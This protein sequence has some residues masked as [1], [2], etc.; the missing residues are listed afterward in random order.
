MSPLA[1]DLGRALE[2]AWREAEPSLPQRRCFFE[3]QAK[4]RV[5]V[6]VVYRFPSEPASDLGNRLTV[7]LQK[8]G[9]EASPMT[10]AMPGVVMVMLELRAPGRFEGGLLRM[11]RMAWAWATPPDEAGEG[12]GPE[13]APTGT[14]GPRD[15]TRVPATVQPTGLA[16]EVDKSLG[17]ALEKVLGVR[18]QLREFTVM[19][20]GPASSAVQLFYAPEGKPS[21]QGQEEQVQQALAQLGLQTLVRGSPE[22]LDVL[23]TGGKL[24]GQTATGG[25]IQVTS[26][27]VEVNVLFQR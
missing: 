5:G 25:T 16:Q 21:W 6:L 26:Q 17:P 7:A 20:M 11:Q 23:V 1:Q 8:Q 9:I 19:T 22:G 27:R 24:A 2:Q 14:A 15:P 10:M 3:T 18:L 13:P 4:G 12:A